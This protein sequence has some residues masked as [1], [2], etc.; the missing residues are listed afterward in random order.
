MEKFMPEANTAASSFSQSN[1]FYK[2]TRKMETLIYQENL[3]KFDKKQL[4]GDRKVLLDDDK[5]NTQPP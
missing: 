1:Q 4:L 3:W 2:Y 5:E